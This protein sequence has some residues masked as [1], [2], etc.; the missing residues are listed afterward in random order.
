MTKLF[1]ILIFSLIMAFL[2]EKNSLKKKDDLGGS[3]YTKKDWLFYLIMAAAMAVFVGLRTSGNDTLAYRIMYEMLPTGWDSLST[4]DWTS[5]AGAPG[6]QSVNIIMKTLGFTT[7][8]YLMVYSLF[9][10][11]VYLWFLRKYTNN[12]P[13]SVFLFF[14]MGV[15]TFTMAAIKQTAAVAFLLIATDKAIRKKYFGFALFAA[16]AMLFHPYSFIYL[17]IPFLDFAP[18]TKKTF[19]FLAGTVFVSIA[20]N[21]LLEPLLDITGALGAGYTA[22]E[23]TGEG[24]NVFR[25]LVVWVPVLLSFLVRPHFYQKNDRVANIV[26]NASMINAMIMFVGL[27]G[28]AN[29]FARMANYFLIFQAIALP[30]LL[31]AFDPSNR[32]LLS[33]GA[34]AGYSGYFYYGTVLANGVFDNLYRFLTFSEY[35]EQLFG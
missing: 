23:L 28:T 5:L 1:P 7:Q 12:V 13:F 14:T 27:F 35:F 26:I 29:Y 31:D 8:D 11:S 18:W 33:V 2:S 24:V 15:Y 21:F 3:Y 22:E 32:K 25:V 19:F 6:H 4:V 9:T 16:I 20:F 30:L 17:I 10:V 34:V